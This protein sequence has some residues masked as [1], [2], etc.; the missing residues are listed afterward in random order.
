MSDFQKQ[1]TVLLDLAQKNATQY[2]QYKLDS[3]NERIL[4]SHNY[5]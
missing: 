3:N 5:L 1:H 2:I 4:S